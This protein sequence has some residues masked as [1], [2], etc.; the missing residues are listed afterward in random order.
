MLDKYYQ[1]ELLYLRELG[2]EFA[3]AHPTSA[4]MLAAPGSDPD[5]E[6]L[7]EGFSFLSARIRQKLEDELPE[8]THGLMALLCPHYLRPVP[9]MTILEFQPVLAALRQTRTVPR[10]VE[11][12]SVPVEG[13]SCRFRTAYQVEL[14]PLS[15]EEV[16]LESGAGPSRLLLQFRLWNQ[17]RP[18]TLDL[19]RLRLHLHG[20]PSVSFALYHHLRN[21][22]REVALWDGP[23]GAG[24]PPAGGLRFAEVGFADEDAVLDYPARSFPGYRLL[25]EYLAFPAKF[26]FLD[27]LG[28]ETLRTLGA[29]ERFAVEVRFDRALPAGLN[30]GKEEIR[31]FCTPVVN[32]FSHE[33]DPI[34][35]DRTRSEYRLRPAGTDPL[36][37][38]VNS[39][40]IVSTTRTG[41]GED[42]E[43]PDFYSFDHGGDDP[44]RGDAPVWGQVPQGGQTPVR[45]QAPPRGQGGRLVYYAARYRP[46]VVDGRTDTYLAFVDARGDGR[47]PEAETVS[48]RLTCT[49]RRLP[50]ALRVGDLQVPADSTPEFVR[51][52]N[53]TPPTASIPPP[54]EGDLHW[55][56][57]SHLALNYL[58][59]ADAE[60]LRGILSLYNFQTLHDARAA[61][62]NTRRLA[63]IREV[64]SRPAHLVL[65]DGVV[66]GTEVT[67]ELQEDH[68]AG[69][70]DL[71]LFAT[72]L[73]EFF[74]LHATLNSYTR[75]TV[76]GVQRG[77][78][79]TWPARTGKR[80]LV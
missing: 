52:R 79:Y 53:L 40:D 43:I 66:R 78:V 10:G 33:A 67:V 63:G 61:V 37:Y 23:V 73:N 39:I 29:L 71:Y 12:R 13:T 45:G 38:E 2:A 25:Q 74:A 59:L 15:L 21:H 6:R 57:L 32:L 19:R 49:N 17:A 9:A 64:R 8:V 44:Q 68:F 70:G 36:H 7:L 56:L 28:L 51:F 62:A 48:I 72:L 76:R 42:R 75:L 80:I 34:R 27:L 3:R 5:V 54:L 20:D 41:S 1:E 22:V 11:V 30:P 55:R 18:E 77:E 69:E 50:E 65:R 31:L 24:V 46:S 4:Y 47:A 58:S 14:N 26:L 60:T 16:R 35:V